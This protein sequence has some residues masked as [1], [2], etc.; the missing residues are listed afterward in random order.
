[1]I[2]TQLNEILNAT[3]VNDLRHQIALYFKKN[4]HKIQN[5]TIT[6]AAKECYVSKSMIIKFVKELGYEGYIDFKNMF[7]E[8]HITSSNYSVHDFLFEA[9]SILKSIDDTVLCQIDKLIDA[10]IKSRCVYAYGQNEYKALCIK[11]QYDFDKLS[12]PTIVVDEAFNKQYNIKE[13]SLLLMFNIDK[14]VL[15]KINNPNFDP[16]FIST[17]CT[18]KTM[19]SLFFPSSNNCSFYMLSIIEE[20]IVIK[21]NERVHKL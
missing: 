5:I 19:H 8:D 21:I 2:I 13:N 11:L 16:W 9:S 14:R 10:I 7:I 20:L 17:K 18:D 3:N 4:H 15:K 12:I 6:Q 1:M